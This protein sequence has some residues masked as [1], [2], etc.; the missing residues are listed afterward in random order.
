MSTDGVKNEIRARYIKSAATREELAERCA[1]LEIDLLRVR[2]D[3]P[4]PRVKFNDKF[5]EFID[6]K[7]VSKKGGMIKEVEL[8]E[9]FK[10]WWT[11]EN[12]GSRVPMK[13]ELVAYICKKVGQ[14]TKV[15]G[16]KALHG[17]ALIQQAEYSLE[18]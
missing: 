9:E 5:D 13:K 2:A 11:A 14:P 1:E 16:V 12:N 10:D 4:R 17:V 7:I 6:H 15:A 3:A 18:V 8:Y